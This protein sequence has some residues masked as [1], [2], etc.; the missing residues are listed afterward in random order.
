MVSD[1]F[2]ALWLLRQ[3]KELAAALLLHAALGMCPPAYRPVS[4]GRLSRAF[5]AVDTGELDLNHFTD[6]ELND[7]PK[8]HVLSP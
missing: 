6:E 8:D 3:P 1:H 2:C 4:A 5:K 7:W